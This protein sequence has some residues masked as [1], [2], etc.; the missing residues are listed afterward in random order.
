M[1]EVASMAKRICETCGNA[2]AVVNAKG[3]KRPDADYWLCA[4]CL[5]ELGNTTWSR[6]MMQAD[7]DVE[8]YLEKGGRLS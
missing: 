5:T 7:E 4:D 8:E 2:P 1:T 6:A 3:L